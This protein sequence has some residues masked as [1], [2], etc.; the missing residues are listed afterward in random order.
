MAQQWECL[1]LWVNRPTS[2]FI[3]VSP[4]PLAATDTKAVNLGSSTAKIFHA[5]ELSSHLR[6]NTHSNRVSQAQS[7]S[8]VCKSTR[9]TVLAC[10]QISL[11]THLTSIKATRCNWLG[12]GS[13]PPYLSPQP[14]NGSIPNKIVV[15]CQSRNLFDPPERRHLLRQLPCCHMQS[16]DKLWHQHHVHLGLLWLCD[17]PLLVA[18]SVTAFSIL[19]T[20]PLG[21]FAS[22]S[23]LTLGRGVGGGVCGGLV[24]VRWRCCCII[25]CGGCC[26]F[27][28]CCGRLRLPICKLFCSIEVLEGDKVDQ[29][30]EYRGGIIVGQVNHMDAW[31][32]QLTA[33]S[34]G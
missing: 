5:H 31:E 14:V 18:L 7:F 26:R 11:Q 1:C 9:Q 21:C 34:K 15:L 4:F 20:L 27:F 8:R 24:L 3:S 13:T 10:I 12:H 19:P 30:C 6:P 25:W 28:C 32:K 29:G 2:R 16:V 23:L 33:G 22:T 17:C